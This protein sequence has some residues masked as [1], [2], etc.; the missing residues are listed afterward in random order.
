MILSDPNLIVN[1]SNELLQSITYIHENGDQEQNTSCT[2]TEHSQSVELVDSLCIKIERIL[3]EFYNYPNLNAT[4]LKCYTV[5]K[6]LISSPPWTMDHLKMHMTN[7]ITS[8]LNSY[9]DSKWSTLDDQNQEL[10]TL[11]CITWVKNEIS[12]SK[13]NQLFNQPILD[14]YKQLA[15]Q[16]YYYKFINQIKNR[17]SPLE[18]SAI[19]SILACHK[20]NQLNQ[21][22]NLHEI[23]PLEICKSRQLLDEHIQDLKCTI[24]FEMNQVIDSEKYQPLNMVTSSFH[25]TS[26]VEL[27]N[28]ANQII[29]MLQMQQEEYEPLCNDATLLFCVNLFDI[30]LEYCN[31]MLTSCAQDLKSKRISINGITLNLFSPNHNRIEHIVRKKSEKFRT[32]SCTFKTLLSDLDQL[33][34]VTKIRFKRRGLSPTMHY[35]DSSSGGTGVKRGFVIPDYALVKVNNIASCKLYFCEFLEIHHMKD[36]IRDYVEQIDSKWNEACEM[37]ANQFSNGTCD[38]LN[39]L[40]GSNREGNASPIDVD[41]FMYEELFDRM[42]TSNLEMIASLTSRDCFMMVMECVYEMMVKEMMNL[43]VPKSVYKHLQS[44][45]VAKIGDLLNLNQILLLSDALK[46]L[47]DYVEDIVPAQTIQ[48]HCSKLKFVIGELQRDG[49]LGGDQDSILSRAILLIKKHLLC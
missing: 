10:S 41:R 28:V 17:T 15:I 29:S 22:C 43:I 21:E 42:L 46:V 7:L 40:I 49:D 1:H 20:M 45:G 12:N 8:G 30:V 3:M 34:N 2:L 25:S 33:Q 9:Y 26:V 38:C 36:L 6:T 13:W 19:D 39:R 4:L 11:E 32:Q 48:K 23:D 16:V 37:L 14:D 31:L 35:N 24:Q 5:C 47:N 18:S 44:G 27:F